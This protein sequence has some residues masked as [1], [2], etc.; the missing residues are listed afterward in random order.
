M[1]IG[2]RFAWAHLPKTGGDATCLMFRSV[3]GLVQFSD[4]LE[5][6]DKHLPFFAREDE[7][8]GRIRVMNIRRLPAWTLSGAHHKASHGLAPE[9]R[10][11]PLPTAEEMAESTDGDDLLTWM[12]D[13]DRLAVD[14]W[15]RCESLEE[16]LLALLDE[17]GE[18]T[19]E[20]RASVRA[21]GRVNQASYERDLERAFTTAQIE[22]MYERNPGWAA[23]ERK[24]YGD[25][26]V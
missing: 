1:V 19:P 25:L 5:S 13:H 6:D 17:L 26:G 9:F 11:L 24:V 12:T 16:D 2:A 21:V 20:A 10:P 7:I 3:P 22:R 14:R 23:I 18:L 8:A 4:P 15:L